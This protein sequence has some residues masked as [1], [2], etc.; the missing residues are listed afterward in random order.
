MAGSESAELGE[1]G[2]PL[3][4][5]AGLPFVC[6]TPNSPQEIQPSSSF[7]ISG[8]AVGAYTALV[9][10][11]T[12][13]KAIKSIAGP[14]IDITAGKETTDYWA[15]VAQG[16]GA[17]VSQIPVAPTA[18]DYTATIAQVQA[19]RAQAV[20]VGL[21]PD[22]TARFIQTASQNEV[23]APVGTPGAALTAPVVQAAGSLPGGLYY[24]ADT[25]P[26]ADTGNPVVAAYLGEMKAEGQ[27]A[28][29]GDTSANSWMSGVVLQTAIEQLG[30]ANV[31]RADLLNLLEHG[32]VKNVPVLG[33][34][35]LAG[36]PAGFPRLANQDVAIALQKGAS[37]SYVAQRERGL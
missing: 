7:C 12:G 32:A 9:R 37:V 24:T 28:E 10:Y 35:S 3:F 6:A 8:G 23:T 18:T 22:Q 17:T 20:L 11:L 4:A 15:G 13:T 1:A 21:A 30:A 16:A 33:T 31:S 14:Y 5:A 19:A 2:Q 26:I 27:T 34:L 29:I 25:P 36:A